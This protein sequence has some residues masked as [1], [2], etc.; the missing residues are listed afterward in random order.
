[1][2]FEVSDPEPEVIFSV[3]KGSRASSRDARENSTC[4]LSEKSFAGRSEG[5]ASRSVG[6]LP[7]NISFPP[8]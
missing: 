8:E 4:V 7:A 6:I 2:K 1:M 3:R 5:I